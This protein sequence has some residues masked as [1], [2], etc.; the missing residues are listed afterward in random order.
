VTDS[1]SNQREQITIGT[2]YLDM[3][4]VYGT[5][6]DHS[7][8]IYR[9]GEKGKLKVNDHDIYPQD[10]N[11]NFI[12]ADGRTGNNYILFALT[13][14]FHRLHNKL[15]DAIWNLDNNLTD[16]QIFNGA[17]NLNTAIFQHIVYDE[18]LPLLIGQERV[19]DYP[20][21]DPTRNPAVYN[22]FTS[23]VFRYGHGTLTEKINK[24]VPNSEKVKI[25]GKSGSR[26][27][28]DAVF[29]ETNMETTS[30]TV[31]KMRSVHVVD[32]VRDRVRRLGGKTVLVDVISLDVQ[33]GRD[34]G[35]PTYGQI[36]EDLAQYG[37][38]PISSFDGFTPDAAKNQQLEDLYGTP[39][40]MDL[41]IG[42]LGEP[43]V[44]NSNL[45][46]VG[47]LITEKTFETARVADR[48]WYENQLS[49][50]F[51]ANIKAIKFADVLNW[52]MI[53]KDV[54]FTSSFVVQN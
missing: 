14:V 3:E 26:F 36:R 17:R 9:S 6:E 4:T 40:N 49:A 48:F 50:N 1:A 33:R 16:D 42:I 24:L 54:T 12:R 39:N 10:Q 44:E 34:H 11:D 13:M 37:I 28:S 52:A 29:T 15:C 18:Y 51:V 45:G 31:T 43:N 47:T 5:N 46:E 35:L 32:E 22:E 21:Y 19:G 20:G 2:F 38:S 27:N 25:D 8:N 53:H 30:Q 41:I 23:A 7:S